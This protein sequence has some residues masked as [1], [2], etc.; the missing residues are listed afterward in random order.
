ML[1]PAVDLEYTG[2]SSVRP[3]VHRFQEELKDYF[4]QIKK[5]YGC[6][7]VVYTTYRFHRNY[8][9]EFNIETLWIRDVFT[10]PKSFA[11]GSWAIWQFSGRGHLEGIKT[12]VD[13]NVLNSKAYDL[14][15]LCLK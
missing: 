13:L 14:E 11:K 10:R 2:N 3:S 9:R 7:P 12:R 8:L 5:H 1:W 6:S 4:S 15:G